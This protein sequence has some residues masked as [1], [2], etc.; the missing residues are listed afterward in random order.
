[1][2]LQ[3]L[4]TSHHRRTELLT[5]SLSTHPR[6]ILARTTALLI[7]A[8]CLR[9]ADPHYIVFSAVHLLTGVFDIPDN[10]PQ[11]DCASFPT[12]HLTMQE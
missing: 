10:L 7:N 9:A 2:R 11:A 3:R 12:N 4:V 5:N 8:A 6:F 1:L